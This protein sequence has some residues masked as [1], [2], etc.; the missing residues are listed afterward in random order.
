MRD[1]PLFFGPLL[2]LRTVPALSQLPPHEL[3]AL[4]H[5]ADQL[6]VPAG[7]T[8][9]APGAS[10]EV[11]HFLVSGD[12][13]L[14]GPGGERR[15]RRDETIGVVEGLA[16]RSSEL[17]GIAISDTVILRLDWDVQLELWERHFG[18]LRAT[19]GS[20]ATRALQAQAGLPHVRGPEAA[21]VP[22][23]TA[24]LDIVRRVLQLRELALFPPTHMEALVE[25]AREVTVTRAHAGE[26]VMSTTQ[27]VPR[28]MLL[29]CEGDLEWVDPTQAQ[30]PPAPLGAVALLEMLAGRPFTGEVRARTP[31]LAFELSKDS[32]LD[33]LDDHFGL[34]IGFMARLAQQ[35]L[36]A[37]RRV[38]T[39]V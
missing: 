36:L 21:S 13:L 20:L 27:V 32:F 25:M 19:L 34:A 2:H 35:V 33:T 37:E 11:L 38:T 1:S 16:G 31:V 9:F 24:E 29:L 4:A 23:P 18:L 12:L 26:T 7:G 8:L 22:A 5:R 6:L 17:E 10:R 15:A 28:S 30:G 39:S 14:R 3:A